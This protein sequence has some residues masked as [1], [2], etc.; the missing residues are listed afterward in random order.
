MITFKVIIETIEQICKESSI[1][2]GIRPGPKSTYQNSYF[3][4]LI[5][6]KSLFGFSSE[7]SFLRFLDKAHFRGLTALPEHSWF[8]RKAKKL[9]PQVERVR[10]L[11]LKKLGVRKV[12]IRIVD[13]VP[14]PVITYARAKR[15]KSFTPQEDASFGY[16]AATKTKY[17]GQKLTILTTN[18]GIPTDYYCELAHRHDVNVFKELLRNNNYRDLQFIG[19]KGY[20]MKE[21]DKVELL[22]K[23]HCRITTPF[24]KNQKKKLTKRERKLLKNRKII[25]T[26]NS[27]LTDQMDLKRT[28]AK[29]AIGLKIRVAGIMLAMTFGIYF[30]QIFGRNIL[31][32]KS[33]IT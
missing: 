30:N 23:N 32:L 29:S 16:C 5:I 1:D 9:A 14:V 3:I 28:R 6:L 11:L 12:K 26:I 33:I 18:Q 8:N 10:Q 17:F 13:S 27:Q 20:L 22:Y 2:K 31:S 25:E 7:L 15:C 24:K 21:V 19:D 4:K